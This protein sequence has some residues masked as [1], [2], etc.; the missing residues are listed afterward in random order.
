MYMTLQSLII[1]HLSEQER[2]TGQGIERADL[3]DWYLETKENDVANIEE[4]EYEKELIGKVL[5]KLV[6]VRFSTSTSSA[7]FSVIMGL[8]L[9]RIPI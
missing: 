1:L 5:N 2:N 7:A 8:T 3:I 4:L 9:D 6:K